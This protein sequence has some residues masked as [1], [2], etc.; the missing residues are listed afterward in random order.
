MHLF[1]QQALER[2][3]STEQLSQPQQLI[4]PQLWL[5]LLA[6]LGFGAYILLWAVQGRLPVR[7]EGRGLLVRPGS[8]QAVQSR[9]SGPITSIM[10]QTGRCVTKGQALA[11]M[12]PLSQ[13]LKREEEL[14]ALALLLVQ[15][16]Q[17]AQRERHL[18][19]MAQA[20]LSRLLPYRS[21]GAI[22]EQTFFDKT[23][24]IER[25][26]G[27]GTVSANRRQQAIRARQTAI[28]TLEQEMA[29]NSVVVAPADGCVVNVNVQPGQVVQSGTTLVELDKSRP[30]DPLV[31]LAFFPV[32]DGKRLRVGQRVR[33]TPSTTQAHRHG[34]I[35]GTIVD[36]QPLP[37][38]RESLLNRL[39]I[40]S[41]VN[42]VETP[43]GGQGAGA[44]APMIQVR[45]SLA[46][47][48]ANRSGYDWGGGTGPDL[49]LSAGTTTSVKVEVEGR[50]PI[51]YLIPQLRDL[52]G[53]Y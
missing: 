34:G 2:I 18:Q 40:A 45:T 19:A 43:S 11:R 30:T 39:G 37:V 8:L 44:G 1:R 27:E 5:L 6:L 48:P 50:Q 29:Q 25:L 28:R 7:I 33:V 14:Q 52:S 35:V 16:G 4:R 41:L 24:E 26:R 49:Q 10:V 21:S 15:D 20:D 12:D 32:Q 51:S 53:I 31:S 46:L 42:T 23:R 17:E 13:R 36:I 9:T 22:S 47:N 3:S 38:N